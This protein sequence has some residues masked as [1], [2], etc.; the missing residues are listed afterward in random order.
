MIVSAFGFTAEPRFVYV[1]DASM[2]VTVQKTQVT[3]TPEVFVKKDD[4]IHL[5]GYDRDYTFTWR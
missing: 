4:A 3:A 1:L 5:R 2:G